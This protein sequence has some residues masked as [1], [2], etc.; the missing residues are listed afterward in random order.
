MRDGGIRRRSLPSRGEESRER[1]PYVLWLA[2]PLPQEAL[3]RSGRPVSDGGTDGQE[4]NR[5]RENDA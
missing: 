4:Q 2:L 5:G 3:G 1:L